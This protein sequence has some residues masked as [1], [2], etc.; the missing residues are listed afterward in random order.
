[1]N[2]SIIVVVGVFPRLNREG[3]K[4]VD[5]CSDDNRPGLRGERNK[6]PTRRHLYGINESS[7][8]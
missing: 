6:E 2:S 1:M 5:A 8:T 4:I 7:G 3:G